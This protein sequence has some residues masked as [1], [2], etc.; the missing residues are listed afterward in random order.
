MA[1]DSWRLQRRWRRIQRPL[2]ASLIVVGGLLVWAQQH[3]PVPTV[4]TVVAKVDMPAGH[5]VGA[6]D[7]QVVGW[8][9]DGHPAPAA[10]SP[11]TILGRRA[12]APIKAGEPLTDL[13]VVGPSVLAATGPGLVAIALNPDPL[14]V[15]GVIRPGDRVNLVGQTDAGPRTLV[16]GASV[17]TLTEE[18]G[19]VLAVPGTSAAAVMQASATDSIAMVLLAAD[20]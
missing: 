16:Q 11:E 8:P 9:A 10:S 18:S 20:Q 7:V 3:G 2:A 13:R 14:T 6:S 15:S 4:A 19:T 17:L 1:I 12:T 5:I